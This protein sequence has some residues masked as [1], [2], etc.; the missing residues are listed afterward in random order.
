MKVRFDFKP[1]ARLSREVCLM[2]G[3]SWNEFSKHK[4]LFIRLDLIFVGF[5]LWIDFYKEDKPLKKKKEL[6]SSKGD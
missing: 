4:S 2:T 6:K 5:Y 1:W 3:I